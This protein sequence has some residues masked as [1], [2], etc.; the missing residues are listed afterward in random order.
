M[1]AKGLVLRAI[2]LPFDEVKEF[3]GSD[4]VIADTSLKKQK[5]VQHL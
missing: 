2:N 3:D 4:A 1:D 5:K